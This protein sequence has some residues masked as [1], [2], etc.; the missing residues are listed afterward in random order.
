MNKKQQQYEPLINELLLELSNIY[1]EQ[2]K[3][4][5]A[6]EKLSLLIEIDNSNSNVYSNLSKAYI[7]N[8]Q[9]DKKAQNIFEKTLEFTPDN[10]TLKKVLS[11]IYLKNE[12]LDDQ[13]LEI[14][15]NILHQDD[16]NGDKLFQKLLKLC[17][18]QNKFEIA[19]ELIKQSAKKTDQFDQA[20]RLYLNESWKINRFDDISQFLKDTLKSENE[21]FYSQL[22]I[23]N[24]LKAN[25]GS[26]N[27][28]KLSEENLEFCINY[29]HS[30]DSINNMFDVY[31]FITMNR[32]LKNFPALK[33]ID[34]KSGIEEFELFLAGNSFSNIWDQGLNKKTSTAVDAGVD[35]GELW[36]KLK[37]W[38]PEIKTID[39]IDSKNLDLKNINQKLDKTNCFM[40]VK[41]RKG[42]YK[43][44]VKPLSESIQSHLNNDSKVIQAFSV[45]DGLLL[46]WENVNSLIKIAVDFTNKLSSKNNGDVIKFQTDIVIHTIS[47]TQNRDF[48]YLFDDL[49]MALTIF[50]PEKE[51]ISPI[52]IY[53]NKHDSGKIYITSAVNNLIKK[54]S[55]FSF[56]PS[57]LIAEH[58]VSHDKYLVY[59]MCYDETLIKINK[60]ELKNIGRYNLIKELH[61]SEIF[62]SYKAIDTNLERPVIIKILKPEF[63]QANMGFEIEDIFLQNA[64][65]LGKQNHPDIALI[66]DVTKEQNLYYFAREFVEGDHLKVPKKLNKKI[67][68]QRAVELSINIADILSYSHENN[69]VHGRLKPN[70]IF[71]ITKNGVKLTDFQIS[72][73]TLN[74]QQIENGSL[75]HLTYHA[76]EFIK[77]KK[78]DPKSD[79]YSLGVILYELLTDKNPFFFKEKQ[80]IIDQ[81]MNKMP[82]PITKHNPKLSDELNKIVFKAIEKDPKKRFESMQEF[83]GELEKIIEKT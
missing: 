83:A 55:T 43:N 25:K 29:I 68:W 50:K 61:Q 4:D 15:K 81:I 18:T 40:I 41:M 37:V 23:L 7:L 60:G 17:L 47:L 9:F 80:K 45:N 39:N 48:T 35:Y 6:I 54:V 42:T 22:F 51:F 30:I 5:K 57:E 12:R 26:T 79:I 19:Q 71:I 36:G 2:G 31:L 21:A 66:Y 70:N 58:P 65:L 56:T 44:I 28:F 38:L 69:Y 73:I 67:N 1:L 24:Q 33:K 27:G 59:K 20:L 46:F 32:L 78:N 77:D 53:E 63:I 14:Y 82:D 16:K 13:A 3:Y 76:P 72:D 34:K 74:V 10:L 75:E 62:I 64:K 11:Q 52:K 8:K 49:E